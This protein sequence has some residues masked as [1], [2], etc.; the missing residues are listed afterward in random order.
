MNY[1]L[2]FSL[3][4][5]I[6]VIGWALLL[7][8]PFI[9]IWSDRLAGYS[10]P[11]VLSVGYITLLLTSSSSEGG[12]GSLTDVMKLF[13]YEQSALAAWIH[14]LAFDLFIGAWICREARLLDIKFWLVVPILVLTFLFGP[15]GFLAFS[16]LKYL[17]IP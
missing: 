9:P 1:E 6:A 2:I 5:I 13:T 7:A 14:F 4:S 12:Y 16:A 8:S 11:L 3:A 17:K 15:F 10:I